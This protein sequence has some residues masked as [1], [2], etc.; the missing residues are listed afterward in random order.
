[1][2]T[3]KA[4]SITLLRLHFGQ[5]HLKNRTLKSAILL[6]CYIKILLWIK[7]KKHLPNHI[8]KYTEI[9]FYGTSSYSG[10]LA[11]HIIQA[12]PIEGENGKP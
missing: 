4:I 9:F 6:L 3:K 7:N 12:E 1:M 10:Y 11:S 5:S 8:N 2:K